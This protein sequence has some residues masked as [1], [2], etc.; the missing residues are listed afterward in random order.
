MI[1]KI[2]ETGVLLIISHAKWGLLIFQTVKLLWLRPYN[3]ATLV[4]MYLS[5]LAP[6]N[7]YYYKCQVP[8]PPSKLP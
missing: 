2:K 7:Q 3:F 5:S 8:G 6:N 4:L 1:I